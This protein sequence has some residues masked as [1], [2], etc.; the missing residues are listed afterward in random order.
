[1]SNERTAEI[2]VTKIDVTADYLGS[3]LPSDP[4]AAYKA[5]QKRLEVVLKDGEPQLSLNFFSRRFYAAMHVHAAKPRLDSL[6]KYDIK[7]S[8]KD[9]VMTLKFYDKVLDYI[10]RDFTYLVGSRTS[11]VL[12]SSRG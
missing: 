2:E 3:F 1:M 7:D 10:S 8:M 9:T 6:F 12:G 11:T 4:T 5:I